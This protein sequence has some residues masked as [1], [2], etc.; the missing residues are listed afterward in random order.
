M[1]QYTQWYMEKG[2]GCLIKSKDSQYWRASF[3][4]DGK[5]KF[6]S[7]GTADKREA[8]R[9]METWEDAGR[10]LLRGEQAR[11]V[12][13]EIL[14]EGGRRASVGEFALGWL[15]G[16]KGQVAPGTYEFYHK[17]LTS[18]IRELGDRAKEPI[19][20]LSVNDL[21]AW[22]EVEARKLSTTTVNHHVKAVRM[23]L[24]GAVDAGWL[25][26]NPAA[27]LRPLK[28]TLQE[29]EDPGRRPFAPEELEQVLRAA[30]EEWR[31][32]VLLGG[33][34]GQRL[35]DLARRRWRDLSG[36]AVHFEKTQK[37]GA[38]VWVPLPESVAAEFEKRR[39]TGPAGEWNWVFPQIYED[40]TVK[41]KGKTNELSRQF[42]LI[43]VKAG[44]REPEVILT[45]KE[46]EARRKAQI[47]EL[48]AENRRR[49]PSELSFHSLRHNTRTWLEESGAPAAVIDA[50]MGQDMRTGRRTYTHIGQE[51]IRAAAA[52][53]VGK[54]GG[55]N[56]KEQLKQ[57]E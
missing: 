32:M 22:R 19:D 8:R 55:G 39:P 23:M 52:G 47:A 9:I 24:K 6:R 4:V 53:L 2:M 48:G 49:K 5:R 45:P 56:V 25:R 46:R 37:T 3:Y 41:G 16:R 12:L 11:K 14:G 42:A 44:L 27:G 26:V 28:A 36:S 20:G 34:T 29:S 7:T 50:L 51:A 33:Y 30:G 54:L 15:A 31:G 38:E 17:A 43:L 57:P 35:G 1:Q 21:V 10:R 18:L 13:S 40:L